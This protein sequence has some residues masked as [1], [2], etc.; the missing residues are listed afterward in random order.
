[1]KEFKQGDYV[2][3]IREYDEDIRLGTT[4]QILEVLFY[5]FDLL[6]TQYLVAWDGG[7]YISKSW[8]TEDEINGL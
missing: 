5:S 6:P 3:Y 8:V 7:E 1:M 2:K 4:G